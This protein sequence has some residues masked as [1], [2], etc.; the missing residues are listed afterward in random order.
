MKTIMTF[1]PAGKL[2]MREGRNSIILTFGQGYDGI[3]G[4]QG[5]DGRDGVD[6]TPGADGQPGRD[7]KDG[8]DGKSAYQVAVDNGF[9][10]T[11]SEWLALLKGDAGDKG[12]KGDVGGQGIPGR[13]GSD[14]INGKDGADGK[15]AYQYAVA[16]GYTGTEADFSALLAD[17][18]TRQYVNNSI[19]SAIYDSWEASV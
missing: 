19:Q 16:G 1:L 6:G 11:E 15:G 18:A 8:R 17:A 9:I 13:N 7:G 3:D 2:E 4:A 10:G 5:K 12:D 14:G